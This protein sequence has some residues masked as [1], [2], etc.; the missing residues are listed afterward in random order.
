MS[1]FVKFEEEVK[2]DVLSS[3]NIN[4]NNHNEVSIVLRNLHNEN[5]K[6]QFNKQ[7]I[8]KI[9]DLRIDVYMSFN[10]R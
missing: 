4:T 2:I 7:K 8:L 3:N 10:P 6:Y 1:K 5:I 9:K